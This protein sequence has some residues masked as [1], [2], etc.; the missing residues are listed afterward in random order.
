MFTEEWIV[1]FLPGAMR[2][3]TPLIFAA[4]GVLLAERS[5]VLMI[6]VEGAMLLG[7]L[8]SIVVALLTGDAWL[9]FLAAGFVGA[10]AGLFLGGMT[11]RLPTDQ[12]VVGIAFN[13]V[14]LGLTS[15]V[16]RLLGPVGA[17]RIAPAI[18][19]LE[20]PLMGAVVAVPPL[21]GTA[22][23]LTLGTWILLFRTG[24][25]LKLRSMGEKA[26]AAHAAGINVV[27]SRI[28][29]VVVAGI[30]CALGGAALTIG[31]VR[32]FTDNITLGRGFIALA[33]VYFGR[34]HPGW[35]LLGC[36]LFGMGE[37]VAL[38]LQAAGGGGTPFYLM[39][40]PYLLTLVVVGITGKAVGPQDAGKPYGRG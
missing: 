31:W 28:V 5:G 13:L 7:A 22:L 17:Y 32:V 19:T 2:A 3:A 15:F 39:T 34:W 14:V 29:V 24:P 11:V 40:I 6:G 16:F 35:A 12:V 36:F 25:G 20:L 26:H 18:P 8:F 9:G 23:L 1:A 27:K 33:A 38:R 30:L 37:A 21:T 10:V 4:L